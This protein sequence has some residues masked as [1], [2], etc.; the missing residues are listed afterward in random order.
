LAE[1]WPPLRLAA[2]VGEVE[3]GPGGGAVGSAVDEGQAI[4]AAVSPG[5]LWISRVLADLLPG[6]GFIFEATTSSS[7]RCMAGPA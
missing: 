5:Q 6:A 7:L 4:L 1:A 2:H 3:T